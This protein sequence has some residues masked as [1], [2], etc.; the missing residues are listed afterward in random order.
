MSCG[1][2]SLPRGAGAALLLGLLAL[3]E[4]TARSGVLPPGQLPPC[5]EVLAF[6]LV[7][8]N[9]TLMG[10]EALSTLQR[11][12]QGFAL[13][14][15][16]GMLLGVGCGAF[17]LL[18]RSTG[19]VVEGLRP[20]PSVALIPVCILFLGM[21][22]RLNI[23][24]AAFACSWPVFISSRDGV[25]GVSRILLDTARTFGHSRA[26][27][28]SRVVLPAALPQ[29]LT[30]LRIGLGIALAVEVSVEMVLPGKGL[31]SLAMHYSLAGRVAP[32]YAAVLAV[33]LTGLLLHKGARTLELR[34]LRPYGRTLGRAALGN[35]RR[36]SR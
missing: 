31:G 13:G 25:R 15:G 22:D 33:G 26:G 6:F 29:I 17:P 34:L 12:L 1:V 10:R 23:A 3:W 20:L 24:V 35:G 16:L 7:P 19:L 18:Q 11:T 27:L 5:S 36:A 28:L 9:L 4:L 14:G 2:R 32:L 30:G 21:G 8:A